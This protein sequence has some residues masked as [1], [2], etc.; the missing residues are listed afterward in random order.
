MFVRSNA[1]GRGHRQ[2]ER[3]RERQREICKKSGRS[4]SGVRQR[5]TTTTRGALDTRLF[6][7]GRDATGAAAAALSTDT[8][9]HNAILAALQ[10]AHALCPQ[11]E[12]KKPVGLFQRSKNVL[13]FDGKARLT[14]QLSDLMRDGQRERERERLAEKDRIQLQWQESFGTV[15][16]SRK[17]Y[18]THADA[19]GCDRLCWLQFRARRGWLVPDFFDSMMRAER[20]AADSLRPPK[21]IV[22]HAEPMRFAIKSS[23][24][25]WAN[26]VSLP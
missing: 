1:V 18:I 13:Q 6:E 25:G 10:S 2:R 12:V 23:T 24:S 9:D 22:H 16:G 20:E 4:R 11:L 14:L 5:E 7:R 19:D 21:V 8:D 3:E 15:V 17:Q 26:A